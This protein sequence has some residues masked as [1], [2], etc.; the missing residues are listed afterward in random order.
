MVSK[1]AK[2]AKVWKELTID[3]EL[4]QGVSAKYEDNNLIVTG[5]KGELS[6]NMKF[7]NITVEVK[8]GKV[9]ISTKRFSQSEKK[10]MF[11]YKA[12]TKN[13]I[14]GV[15]QGFEYK[16]VVVYAKFPITVLS[17]GNVFTVKNLLG[18]KV[19]RTTKIPSDVKVE[20]KAKDIIVTGI[21]KER[22]GQM[23][24]SI[25]Q[26][27]RITHLDRRIIQDGIFITQKPHSKVV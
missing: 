5:P 16:L 4:P 15:T 2:D 25:E 17:N 9:L 23:A 3:L 26:L 13:L 1:Q 12:H 8:D 22:V 11:T 14:K 20:I 18:E 6:K 19:P 7:P 21:D 27:T 10:I 24:A